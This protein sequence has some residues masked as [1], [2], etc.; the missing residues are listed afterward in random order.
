MKRRIDVLS[1]ITGL[2]LTAVAVVSLWLTFGGPVDW[3]A[4]KVAVPLGL[5]AVGVLGLSLSRNHG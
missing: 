1:L 2:L 4:L 3:A 5:I